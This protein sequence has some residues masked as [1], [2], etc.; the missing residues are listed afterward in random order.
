MDAAERGSDEWKKFRDNWMESVTDLN[1]AVEAAV[2][3]LLD[4]YH[5][6]IQ[7]IINDSKDQLMG[8]DWKK[9]LDEWDKAKWLDDRYLDMGSRANGV[10]DFISNV[11]KAMDGKSVKQQQQLLQLMDAETERLN[12]I[13]NLSQT[14]V[15]IANKKLEILQ[16]QMALE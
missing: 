7:K 6:T 15:D 10:L 3:N 11:N 4:K 5:N 2:Q 16:K 12:N 14:Q 13:T 8:G 9:A 1:S